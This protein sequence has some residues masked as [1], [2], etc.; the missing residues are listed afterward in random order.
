MAAT[1]QA[2]GRWGA[3]PQ[4]L[5]NVRGTVLEPTRRAKSAPEEPRD[6]RRWVRGQPKPWAVDLFCGAGGLGLGLK[7]A[8][9]SV[10]ASADSDSVALKTYQANLGGLTFDGDL[11]EP[12]AFVDYLAERGV[13]SVDLVAGGPPCQPFSR[14]GRSKIRDLVAR[15]Q[16]SANDERAELWRSF[17]DVVEHLKPKVVLLENVPDMARWQD[18]AVLLGVMQA[19]REEGFEPTARVLDAY[20]Y[21]VPQHRAR[22]FVVATRKRHFAWPSEGRKQPTLKDAIGDLPVARG[23]QT[24][25]SLPYKGASTP[26]QK[27]A[28]RGVPA[29]ER[30]LI[31]DHWTRAVRKDD[32]EAFRL[33]KPGGTYK[34]LPKK[35]QRYRADI[36]DDK[37]KRLEWGGLSRTITAHIARDGYWYIHPSQNRTLS[38]R[39]AARIQ[40]FP[41]WFQ[42]AGHPTARFRQIGNAVPPALAEAVARQVR[43]ALD[44]KP[45]RA[46]SPFATRLLAW[47][48]NGH[49]RQF[50][51]RTTRNP[52]FIFLA[53]MCLRRTR[54]D[55]VSEVYKQLIRIAPTPEAALRNKKQVLKVLEPLGL[56]WRARNV[57]AAAA[58]I[59]KE[60]NGQVPRDEESLL[61]LTGVGSYVASAVRCFAFGAPSVLLD[62]NTRRITAR[63][64]GVDTQSAWM[65]RLEIYRL[66][67][68][69]GPSAEFNYALLDLGA[70]VC[71]PDNPSCSKC[72]LRRDCVTWKKERVA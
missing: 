41:D 50:P 64:A 69:G 47:H 19:L 62:A 16:R 43:L 40:T 70:L 54:A 39:E 72:P 25:E 32:A 52:W 55:N 48:T 11:A 53:E 3:D 63:Y 49:Y 66:S 13:R 10:I 15:G 23:G 59:V 26:F 1:A 7:R 14:A 33:L 42:F 60:H 12:E 67:G 29:K 20:R 31:H 38:I 6:A 68:S 8:G 4:A 65:T 21:G 30:E 5:P 34:D 24:K 37:Y 51:W 44:A 56:R 71:S 57:T 17:V 35:L 27:R 2:R 45:K 61:A 58:E 28:R 9:F 22:L 36:F 18:G 46:A